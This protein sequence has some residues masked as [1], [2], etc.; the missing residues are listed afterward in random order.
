MD[1]RQKVVFYYDDRCGFCTLGASWLKRVDFRSRIEFRPLASYLQVLP[2]SDPE[3]A[4][5]YH[6]GRWYRDSE[7]VIRGL[8][9]VGFPFNLF[10]FLLWIPRVMR[11]YVYRFIARNRYRLLGHRH[12]VCEREN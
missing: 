1:K 5:L 3:T 12:P 2:V 9:A 6:S 4:W 10:G 8:M 7:A 11:D